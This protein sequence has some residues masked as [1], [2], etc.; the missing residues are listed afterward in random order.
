MLGELGKLADIICSCPQL[1]DDARFVLVP[2]PLDPGMSTALP[3][4]PLPE[5][6]TAELT[7]K[8]PNI[9]FASNPC[10]VRF[11]TQEIVIF[12]EDLLRKMQRNTILPPDLSE[13]NPDITEQLVQSICDQVLLNKLYAN[14]ELD[15]ILMNLLLCALV[16]CR[17]ISAPFHWPRDQSS[18]TSTT[19]CVWPHCQTC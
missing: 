17:H 15:S 6:F 14:W 3:R 13:G 7:A 19:V 1:K 18:G 2:S 12:R 9:S 5:H 11:Y 4:R 16:G 8:I 10:R